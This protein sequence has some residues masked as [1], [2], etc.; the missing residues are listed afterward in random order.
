[1]CSSDLS[2]VTLVELS[3]INSNLLRALSEEC[4]GTFQHSLQV[5]N[6]CT[7]AARKINANVQLVRTAALYHD[8]GKIN[9]PTFFTENQFDIN[10]HDNLTYE[11]S[12]SI[13]KQHVTDGIT[14]A[15]KE[16]LPK[17]I[18][19]FIGSH[20]G[21]GRIKYFYNK[22]CNENP[23]KEIDEEMFSYPGPNPT[24]REQALLM[25]A[26]SVEA[27]SRSLKDYSDKSVS[28]LVNNIIDAQVNEGMFKDT[29]LTFR[30]LEA[31]KE[32]FIERLKTMYHA[33]ISYPELKV[34][35]NGKK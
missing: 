12:V 35:N 13:I 26:D 11:E 7:Q 17:E 28:K 3:N 32:V 6:L 16:N 24:T 30:D 21:N 1:M 5:S 9:N 2:S 15:K 10:P 34:K 22:W 31:I 18:T 19:D 29:P 23:D 4:P 20:H 25:M 8:I 27:A 33:R 14:L